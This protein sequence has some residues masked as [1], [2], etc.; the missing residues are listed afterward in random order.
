MARGRG[1]RGGGRGRSG[2]NTSGRDYQWHGEN[3]GGYDS[4]SRC[5]RGHGRNQNGYYT[6]GRGYQG[7]EGNQGRCDSGGRGFRGRGANH[8]GYS[9]GGQG[10]QGP[11]GMNQGGYDLG[12]R[13]RMGNQNAA[14]GFDG[15]QSSTA[16]ENPVSGIC[17]DWLNG[18]CSRVNCQYMH[19]IPGQ[20]PSAG[21]RSVN[22]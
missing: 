6:G 4:G 14:G 19:A 16:R 9:T 20:V 21:M 3:Q 13:E 22:F 18:T 10:Y 15:T 12:Y 7:H 1:D 17:N 5:F 2:Y 8:G 11:T